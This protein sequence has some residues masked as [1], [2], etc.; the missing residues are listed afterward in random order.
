M[1][2]F[3]LTR[4]EMLPRATCLLLVALVLLPLT[5]CRKKGTALLEQGQLAWDNNDYETA[6][7][8]FEEY[9]KEDASSSQ[10]EKARLQ[11]ANLYLYNLRK[12]DLAKQHYIHL[13]EDFPK[14]AE[15]GVF[16]QRLAESYAG[17]KDYRAAIQEY[18]NLLLVLP[19]F[20]EKRRIRLLIA[21]RYFD[22]N[23]LGQSLAEYEKVI[24]GVA[25]DDLAQ[26]AYLRKGG[27]HMIRDEFDAALSAFQMIANST[28]D[29]MVRRTAR[30]SMADCY[31]RTF[32]F[33]DAVKVLEGTEPDPK[34]PDYIAKRV[35]AIREQQKLRQLAA[36]NGTMSSRR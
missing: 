5:G 6:S 29:S 4:P 12:Y 36:P 2:L 34:T 28:N 1:S 19:D 18:E 30:Y 10:A 24:N 23:E 8:R 16:H 15:L 7:V 26:R 13:I 22:L 31:E 25:F 3:T 35:T 32:K 11:L 9:L 17:S 33:D 21:D 14:S 27:I 20:P